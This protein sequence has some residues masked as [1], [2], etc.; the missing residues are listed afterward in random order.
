M[1]TPEEV[2][3]MLRVFPDTRLSSLD[4]SEAKIFIGD[5]EIEGGSDR[6]GN[7]DGEVDGE[8]EVEAVAEGDEDVEGEEEGE[9][10]GEADGEGDDEG[11]GE[12]GMHFSFQRVL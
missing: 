9:I 2:K 7:G 4:L 6:E 8:M 3:E 1:L 5:G 11:D 10:E 12:G